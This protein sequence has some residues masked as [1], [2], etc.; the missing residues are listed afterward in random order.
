MRGMT[1]D[2][3]E[4]KNIVFNETSYTAGDIALTLILKS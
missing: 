1:R 2:D 4:I 3:R